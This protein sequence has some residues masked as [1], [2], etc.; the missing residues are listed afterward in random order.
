MKAIYLVRHGKAQDAFEMRESVLPVPAENQVRIK[1]EAFGLNFADVMARKGLYRDCPPLPCVIGYDVVGIIDACGKNVTCVNNG[2]RVVAFT[3]FGGYARYAVI[4]EHGIAAIPQ[5]MPLTFAGALAT[6]YCT[7]YYAAHECVNVF[8]G[9][10]VLVHAA[11]GGVGTA[12]VQLLKHKG[13]VIFGTCGSD[14][15]V[16]YLR[17]LGVDHPVNYITTDYRKEVTG[18]LDGKKL[19]VI[20]DSLGGKYVRDGIKLLGAGGKM[21][22]YG[23]AHMNDTKN[24]FSKLAFGVQFGL[25][26]PVNL[27]RKSKSIIGIYLLQLSDHKSH[28][29]YR[30]LHEVVKLAGEGIIKPSAGMEF[31][32]SELPE[33][34]EAFE[35]RKTIGKVMMKW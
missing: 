12:L 18:I 19:D 3:R 20:F 23:G 9:D 10:Q 16:N 17:A 33:A 26:H 15:K 4:D 21:V 14:E 29:I 22:C 31:P 6:Q 27:L 34:H 28:I 7:A 30:C 24:I 25:Y 2:D 32:V 13:A 5:D 35:K 8:A 11:A 1:V